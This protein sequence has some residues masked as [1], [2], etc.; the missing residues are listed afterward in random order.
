MTIMRF[1]S[2]EFSAEVDLSRFTLNEAILVEEQTGLDIEAIGTRALKGNLRSVGALLWIARL[3]QF[4]VEQGI[5][6]DQAA[7][8]LPRDRFDPNLIGME[9]KTEDPTDAPTKGPTKRTSRGT[10]A[11]SLKRKPKVRSG[12]SNGATTS[13]TSPTSS[14]S[15][16]GK[17]D[18]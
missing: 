17:S 1:S 16:P 14:T 4:A 11:P 3:R 6:I 18:S 7:V 10:S 2:P 13:E 12:G 5:S 8:T 9:V 15:D